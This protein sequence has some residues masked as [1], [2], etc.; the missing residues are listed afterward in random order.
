MGRGGCRAG[1]GGRPK[2]MSAPAPAAPAEPTPAGQQSVAF[3]G[4]R[5]AEPA[6]GWPGSMGLPPPPAMPAPALMQAQQMQAAPVEAQQQA[7]PAQQQAM[8]AQSQPQAMPAQQQQPVHHHLA[9]ITAVPPH[10]SAAS[11]AAVAPSQSSLYVMQ[12]AISL[13]P[14][15]IMKVYEG[16]KKH[17]HSEGLLRGMS[18]SARNKRRVKC[19]KETCP[20][21]AMTASKKQAT[22]KDGNNCGYHAQFACTVCEE[23]KRDFKRCTC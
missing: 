9:P 21:H 16:L 19:L 5:P 3:V 20:G 11:T 4:E 22:C 23:G 12:Q 2:L 18:V 13:P 15:D 1:L 17:L 6:P 7:V 14:S 8:P 10:M